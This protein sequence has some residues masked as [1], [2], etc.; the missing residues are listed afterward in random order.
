MFGIFKKKV[1]SGGYIKYY[2]LEE[3]WINGLTE[4]QRQEVKA[5]AAMG[6]NTDP[7]SVDTGD[8]SYTTAS[9]SKFLVSMAQGIADI[10]V[11]DM[12]LQKALF[13]MKTDAVDNHFVLMNMANEYKKII[14]SDESF[15]NKQIDVL[16]KDCFLYD[17]FAKDYYKLDYVS[18]DEKLPSYPAFRE[19]AIA[20]ERTGEIQKA[21]EISKSAMEKKVN[22]KTSFENR[23]TK[24]EKKLK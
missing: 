6:M 18:S 3:L 12:L 9:K 21:I 19:L 13:E 1:K 20:Y 10:K 17:R 4:E 22:E 2:N 23:I 8:L 24:L 7:N 15:Y 14:K 16:K 5:R 11:K